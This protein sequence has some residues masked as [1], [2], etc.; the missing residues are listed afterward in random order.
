ML[1]GMVLNDRNRP[2]TQGWELLIQVKDGSTDWVALKD[3]KESYPVKL[4]LYAVE[5]SIQD[6]PA[7]A[8][9]VPHVLKKTEADTP[10]GEGKVKVL[11]AYSQIWSACAKKYQGS[12]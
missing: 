5:Q 2:P 9:W 7:F 1:I 4:A 11:G 6:K 10:K 8:W 3:F 12:H